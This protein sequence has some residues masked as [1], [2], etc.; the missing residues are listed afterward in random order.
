MFHL[1]LNDMSPIQLERITDERNGNPKAKKNMCPSEISFSEVDVQISCKSE[2][3]MLFS[4]LLK[5]MAPI[6]PE[7]DELWGLKIGPN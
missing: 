5:K 4:H 6:Y 2:K 1:T 3:R 7:T